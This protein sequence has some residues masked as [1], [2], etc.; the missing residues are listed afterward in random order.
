MKT[1]S[2]IIYHLTLSLVVA[3]A[4]VGVM[5][6]V[7]CGGSSAPSDAV[8]S[9]AAPQ[10]ASTAERIGGVV[11]ALR[12]VGVEYANAVAN[13]EVVD[14]TEYEETLLFLERATGRWREVPPEAR[15][16]IRGGDRMEE[17][18]TRLEDLVQAKG[19]RDEVRG[20]VDE[21]LSI[22]KPHAPTPPEII[23]FR[24]AVARADEAIAA[25]KTV[26][27][28]RIGIA[29]KDERV[30]VVLREARTK[31]NLPYAEVAIVS[32]GTRVS[33]SPAYDPV[34]GEAYAARLAELPEGEAALTV[35]VSPP[36]MPRHGDMTAHFT[37]PAVATF[38]VTR[39]GDGIEVAGAEPPAPVPLDYEFGTDVAMALAECG[40]RVVE[41]GPFKI[42]FIN[43]GAEPYWFVRDGGMEIDPVEGEENRHLEV[44]VLEAKTH[45]P[46]MTAGV[47]IEVRRTDGDGRGR[48]FRLHPLWSAFAH[49]GRTVALE[50]GSYV[51]T[52]RVTAPPT[53][54]K[55]AQ[56]KAEFTFV[57]PEAP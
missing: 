23:A 54:H 33:L 53:W 21:A 29:A 24:E 46:V 30:F 12:L 3:T 51:V 17:I 55:P 34:L 42:G 1:K 10:G 25:E 50:P 37:E 44:V 7:A 15:A 18:L 6:L 8:R 32:G 38:R 35:E 52:V 41:S 9:S 26:G 48:I 22:L 5:S 14:S 13:G 27:E 16:G 36:R 47:E 31:R 43:D 19:P 57:V 2:E 56:G 28:Y 11:E 49:Y 39:R 40:D 20:L 45:R 4:P